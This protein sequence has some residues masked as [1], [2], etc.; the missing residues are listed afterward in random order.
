MF[1][2]LVEHDY[3]RISELPEASFIYD[4]TDD[5]Q[6]LAQLLDEDHGV[7]AGDV[8]IRLLPA[9]LGGDGEDLEHWARQEDD[10]SEWSDDEY[11]SILNDD[12]AKL[13]HSLLRGKYSG[14]ADGKE[15][16]E[17][18]ESGLKIAKRVVPPSTHLW[19]ARIGQGHA[20]D[21]LRAPPPAKVLAARGNQQGQPVLYVAGD[22]TTAVYE[23]RPSLG[24]VVSVGR[25][26]LTRPATVCDLMDDLAHVTPFVSTRAEF[27]R[28]EQNFRESAVRATYG[29]RLARP[30]RRSDEA[31]DYL[32]TQFLVTIIS[33]AGFDGVRYRSSQRG[34]TEGVNYLFFDPYIAEPTADVHE[35]KLTHIELTLT[36]NIRRP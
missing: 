27:K 26:R 25:L 36:P 30:V 9:I 14:S 32:E 29:A 7:F 35:V 15:A 33:R 8:G 17:I 18:V 21:A 22:E 12:I 2:R 34:K 1:V 3:C 16:F 11:L 24:D 13:G 19:R 10:W 5:E 23:V 4:P 31:E 28:Y 20:G 6:P